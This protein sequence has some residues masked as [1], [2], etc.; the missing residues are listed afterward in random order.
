QEGWFDVE[1]LDE[2]LERVITA[3]LRGKIKPGPRLLAVSARQLV[4]NNQTVGR[5]R[6]NASAHYDIGNDLYEHMLD[7]RMIYSSAYWRNA[8]DLDSAQEAKLDLICRKLALEPGMTLLDIGCGWGGFSQ[9]AATRYGAVVTGISPAI[10]QVKRAQQRCEGLSVDIR[11]LDYRDVSGTFDRIVSIGMME[12][13]GPKNLRIFFGVCSNLLDPEGMMLHHTIGRNYTSNRSDAWFDKYIFPGG[14]LPSFAQIA[15]A[16]EPDWVIE[17][18][19]NFGPDY[20]RTLMSWSA[21]I[22]ASWED[23][24]NYDEHFRRTWQYYLMGT[25]AG[26]RTRITQLWQVVFR[27][28]RRRTEVYNAVR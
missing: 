14:V 24:P 23:L 12:H 25:A 19:H 2:M 7:K 9:F 20:D 21:N 4:L 13:V 8:T 28:A 11:Q 22:N 3:D 1:A 5:A 27:R 16:A 10:E 6:R 26:F 15:E 18:L 17:D